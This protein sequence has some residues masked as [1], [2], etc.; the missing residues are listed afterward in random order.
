MKSNIPGKYLLV[1]TDSQTSILLDVYT[2]E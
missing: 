1:E 2:N